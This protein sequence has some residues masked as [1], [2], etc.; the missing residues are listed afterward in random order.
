MLKTFLFSFLLILAI[1]FGQ[2][3]DESEVVPVATELKR[4]AP[5]WQIQVLERFLDGKCKRVIFYYENDKGEEEIVKQVQFY[6]NESILEEVDLITVEEDSP[7]YATWNSVVVPHGVK[8][9]LLE[10]GKVEMM[11]CFDRGVL[12]GP[13]KVFY[14]SGQLHHVTTFKQ[15]RP[16]GKFYSYHENGQISV[17]GFYKDG[18]LEGD[19][20]RF[21]D[22]GQRAELIPY[23]NGRIEGNRI[24]WYEKG[25]KK[26]QASY[27]Q[28]ELH[29]IDGR[30]AEVKYDENH[31]IIE[32]QDYYQGLPSGSHIRYYANERQ[33][34][35]LC[36]VNGKK[37]GKE[38]WFNVNGKVIGEKEYNN[39]KNIGT[40]WKKHFNGTLSYLAIY[41]KEGC[42]NEPIREF[43]EQGQKISEY[44]MDCEEQLHGH[45]L[46]WHSNG[47]LQTDCYYVHGELDGEIK[48]FY[49]SGKM[50]SHGVYQDRLRHGLFS[51][52]SEEGELLFEGVFNKGEKEGA[53]IERYLN[54]QLK[55]CRNFM[56]SCFHGD[57]SAWYEDGLL[58][59]EQCYDE[60]KAEGLWRVW[61]EKG[62]LLFEGTYEKD[63][64]VGVHVFYDDQ[65]VKREVVEFVKGKREGKYE[66]FYPNGQ[67]KI[68]KTFVNDLLEGES[69]GFYEN[70]SQA[71][72]RNY[73]NGKLT[74][75][76]KE[77]FPSDTNQIS[78]ISAIYQWNNG[79]L[80]GIQ[81]DFYPSGK[82]KALMCYDNDVYDGSNNIWDEQGNLLKEATYVNKKLEGRYLEKDKEGRESISYYKNNKREGP[83]IVYHSEQ[84]EG[85]EK[86]KII[87]AHYKNN[88][89]HG[90]VVEYVKGAKFLMTTYENGIKEGVE[91]FFY[92]NGIVASH[93]IFKDNVLEGLACQYHTNGQIIGKVE[94]VKGQKEGEEKSWFANGEVK[95]V[96]NYKNGKL[97]GPAEQRNEA[98]VIIFEAVYKEGLPDG[99]FKKYYDSGTLRLK[100]FFVNG[101]LEGKKEHFDLH[102]NVKETYYRD[103]IRVFE[104]SPSD[105]SKK[106]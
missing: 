77:F 99:V 26:R 103:G 62:Q 2:N 5:E 88:Q 33:S 53:F 80:H 101:K 56:H 48:Q 50:K 31:S 15:G 49:S 13:K 69:L 79:M 54:G 42:L 72:I 17:E 27:Q 71:F 85:G 10:T 95:G 76:D 4:Q 75:E 16:E 51:E 41:N 93:C 100:Q 36:Y 94:F 74:G 19:Y 86:I 91:E 81:K 90:E 105:S 18:Q 9:R 66:V 3:S 68:S 14:P 47:Q 34:Y 40:H 11:A 59:W 97:E 106:E 82:M 45:Y 46:T 60:G 44:M 37:N 22:H 52:W 29:S 12:H 67:L 70:G 61:N 21:F 55:L 23:V 83:Y 92:P 57:Q 20:I 65:G 25:G 30:P 6:E 58:H 87:E 102:G 73:K 39:G 78:V 38:Q 8:L 96:Y 104:H 89:L 63:Q 7:G 43:D 24:E 84:T 28:G 1:V 64:P 98:G 35:A 32:V